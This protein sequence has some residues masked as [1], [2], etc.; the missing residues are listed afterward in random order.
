[1]PFVSVSLTPE[2]DPPG[3]FHA[4]GEEPGT[5]AFLEGWLRHV[6]GVSAAGANDGVDDSSSSSWY[7]SSTIQRLAAEANLAWQRQSSTSQGALDVAAA[8]IGDTKAAL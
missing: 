6:D 1:M 4:G 7:A 3:T 2:L 5:A 8:F